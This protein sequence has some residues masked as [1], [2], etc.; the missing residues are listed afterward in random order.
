MTPIIDIERYKCLMINQINSVLSQK[1]KQA[2]DTVFVTVHHAIEEEDEENEKEMKLDI[3][4]I[5]FIDEKEI[6]SSLTFYFNNE[7]NIIHH[8]LDGIV[9]TSSAEGGMFVIGIIKDWLAHK[10][11]PLILSTLFQALMNDTPLELSRLDALTD[12]TKYH[13]YQPF[14]LE[15]LQD[16]KKINLC[17]KL[18][19]KNYNNNKSIHDAIMKSLPCYETQVINGH[20]LFKWDP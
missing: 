10:Q 6:T 11:N 2:F 18:D 16:Q 13:P 12:I 15:L 5:E 3:T 1:I 17:H 4:L 19:H 20:T 7:N 8:G 9:D 14:L